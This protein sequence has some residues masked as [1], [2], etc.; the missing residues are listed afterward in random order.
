MSNSEKAPFTLVWRVTPYGKY[1]CALFGWI[2][3]A[4]EAAIADDPNGGPYSVEDLWR[5]LRECEQRSNL[6]KPATGREA[7]CQRCGYNVAM[8][9]SGVDLARRTWAIDQLEPQIAAL[10]SHAPF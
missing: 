4:V 3:P 7:V 10:I 9:E 1:R 6:V 8:V 5:Q 2:H